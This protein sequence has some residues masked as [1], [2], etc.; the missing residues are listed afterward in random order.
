MLL[1]SISI[2]SPQ[3]AKEF[4]PRHSTLLPVSQYA[5]LLIGAVFCGLLADKAGRRLVWQLSIFGVAVFTTMSAGAPNWSALNVFIAFI[6]LFGGGNRKMRRG[7]LCA[8]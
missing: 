8:H 3:A 2:V 7:S 1:V 5:G 4:G 6:G